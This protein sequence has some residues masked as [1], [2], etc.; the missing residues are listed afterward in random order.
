MYWN[1]KSKTHSVDKLQ[2][3]LFNLLCSYCIASC[4]NCCAIDLKII[5]ALSF[6]ISS[7][8]TQ[9]G[10]TLHANPCESIDVNCPGK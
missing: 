7:S 5:T 1:M 2:N 9:C 6:R 10:S 8:L 4:I 3:E